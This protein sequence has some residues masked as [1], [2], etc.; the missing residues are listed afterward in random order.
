M[1]A[2]ILLVAPY[3][4]LADIATSLKPRLD[5]P[6]EIIVGNLDENWPDIEAVVQQGIKIV[7]SRGGTAQYLRERLQ[8]PVVEIPVT[9]FDILHAISMM[10]KKGYTKLAV[11]TAAN[12]IVKAEHFERIRDI[13]LRF[14]PADVNDIPAK[15]RELV[16]E[17]IEAIVG[18]VY[19]T[20]EA[21][22]NGI[23]GQLLESGQESLLYALNDARRALEA[24]KREKAKI[25][26]M[27]A[28]LNVIDE[29]VLAINSQG[30]VT[31][32]NTAAER[33]FG[34]SKQQVIGQQVQECL[35]DSKLENLL[36]QK[37]K[38]KNVLME[39]GQRKIVSDR[40]PIVIDNEVQGA[41]AVFEEV[42]HIQ[43]LELSIRQKANPKGFVAKHNF[44][45]ITTA[46]QE[47]EK[48]INQA[49]RYARSDGT[50]LIYGETGTGKELFAQSIHNA[51][52][53]AGGPFLSINCA[54]LSESLL[55]SELFG[56]E[57]GSFTGATRGG[58]QGLFE[59][60][61]GGSIFLDEIGEISQSFQAKLL[62]VLQEK[63]VRRVGGDKVIPV[64][65][66]II[67]ATNRDLKNE[68]KEKRFRED[69]YYRL[70]VLELKLPPLRQRKADIIPMALS[71]IRQECIAENKN[72]YWH[73][74][75]IFHGLLQPKW[76]GNARELY[77]FIS[78]LVIGSEEGE[79]KRGFIEELLAQGVDEEPAVDEISIPLYKSWKELQA[80]VF[81]KLLDHYGGNKNKLCEDYKIS[82]MTL[83]RKLNNK[84]DK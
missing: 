83:W 80:A 8:L 54:A 73:N 52:K 65:A 13:S 30:L 64:D 84:N 44:S 14:E 19:S 79:L 67:C 69:L 53:R 47:M 2:E 29:A 37:E 40:I 34:C 5:V 15:V 26:E 48:I 56:Y 18:D 76:E 60:S 4:K 59:L 11:A 31:L 7:C 12:I 32:F 74:D 36:Q 41:V 77:N 62:R 6:F 82:K 25:Q 33:I 46:S 9:S 20:R 10:E 78:R 43:E 49:H 51:S 58:K 3:E 38:E 21:V 17:G 63:E 68:V 24:T 50:V 39:I 75:D 28:I 35:P 27:E 45:H 22:K 72:L 57:A 23:H 70:A 81:A 1:G 16:K 61:H 71:F 55:E 66:R 42:T